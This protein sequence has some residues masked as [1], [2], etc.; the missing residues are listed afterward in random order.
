MKSAFEVTGFLRD[1]PL[2]ERVCKHRS[3]HSGARF[4]QRFSEAC[5]S[6]VLLLI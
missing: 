6:L 1:R 4:A 2:G 5:Q 3:H